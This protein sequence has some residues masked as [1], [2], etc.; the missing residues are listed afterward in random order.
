MEEDLR[1]P[2]YLTD[3]DR[4]LSPG[5]SLPSSSN[6]YSDPSPQGYFEGSR[7]DR[8]LAGIVEPGGDRPCSTGRALLEILL[9]CFCSP[10][11]IR[12]ILPDIKSQKT[13][14]VFVTKELSDG[15]YIHCVQASIEGC[16]Y[17]HNR[18]EERVSP[19]PDCPGTP[20][21]VEIRSSYE[22][23]DTTLAILSSSL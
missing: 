13:E 21:P 14:Q 1:K 20:I 17:G 4:G 10:K 3:L 18:S 15:E 6:L 2:R 8:Q 5:T 12:E 23:R 7:V 22:Q 9:P 19:Y 16:F 11:T